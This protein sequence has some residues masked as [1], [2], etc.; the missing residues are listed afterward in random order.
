MVVKFKTPPW[1]HQKKAVEEIVNNGRN[2][3]ALFF[4]QGTGKTKTVIDAY[5]NICMRDIVFHKCLVIAPL[6][7]I[8]QWKQEFLAFSNIAPENISVVD[9]MTKKDGTILKTVSLKLKKEQLQ[10]KQAR[11]F[12]INTELVANKTLWPLV[13]ELGINFLIVDE[14]HRFKTFNAKRTKILHR[15]IEQH[16]PKYRFILSGTP[17]TNSALDIWSQFYILNPN[18][19]GRNFYSFRGKYFYDKNAGMPSHVHFPKFVPYEDTEDNLNSIIY[20]Y[21]MRVLK[22]DVLDLPEFVRQRVDISFSPEQARIYRQMEKDAVAYFN[23]VDDIKLEESGKVV[24]VEE[25]EVMSADLAITKLIRLQQI[26]SGVF[27]NDETKEVKTFLSNRTKVLKEMLEELLVNKETKIVVWTVWSPTYSIIEEVLKELKVEYAFIT[28]KQSS[29]EKFKAVDDFQNGTCRV[30]VANQ[31]AAG[32]GVNLTAGNYA[33]Y[34]TRSFNLEHDLQSEARIHRGGQ[35][36]TCYRI[37]FVTPYTVD[38]QVLDALDE[39]RKLADRVVNKK[40]SFDE[41]K[42]MIT[43]K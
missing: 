34:F 7:T 40:L 38:E 15:F 11:I 39:K 5:R 18:I 32:T 27:V 35:K 33:I 6:I 29:E 19:F 21:G 12:I 20:H 36:K 13:E 4:E 2:Y 16:S 10:N 14:S 31:A 1:E 9:G 8:R 41:I 26:V 17:V 22:D 43:K 42:S 25:S 24:E 23:E 37:D 28:G 3:Y 30:V